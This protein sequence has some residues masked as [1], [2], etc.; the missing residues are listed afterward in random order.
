MRSKQTFDLCETKVKQFKY[1]FSFKYERPQPCPEANLGG[2]H[3][4]KVSFSPSPF[5]FNR[6]SSQTTDTNDNAPSPA[7]I[8]NQNL[9]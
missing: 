5:Y 7:C 2:H 3:Y 4:F 1:P 8:Y 9:E 6:I